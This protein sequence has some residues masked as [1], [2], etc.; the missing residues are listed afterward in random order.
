VRDAASGWPPAR[1][2]TR[3]LPPA[4]AALTVAAFAVF[5]LRPLV[6]KPTGQYYQNSLYWV[7]WYIGL[8]A[9]LLGAFGLAALARRTSR[10]LLTWTDHRAEARTWA[11]PL[12]T[13]LWVIVTVLWRPDINPDQPWAST[14]L[15]PFV[16]PGL[17]LGAVWASAWLGE[18]AGQ[19]GQ[20]RTTSG[21][22]ASCCAASLLIPA[23][24]T[25][26]DLDSHLH[27]RGLAFQRIGAGEPGTVDRLCATIGPDASVVIL[28]APTA[29]Q[30]APV[31]RI[32]CDTPTA[33]IDH[34]TAATVDAVI[35]GIQHAGRRP[36]LLAQ[37]SAELAPY[38]G[39]PRKAVSLATTEEARDLTTP[40]TRTWPVQYT[41]WM[42]NPT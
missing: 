22:V 15:V 21:L 14:R 30:F 8:P 34:P 24:L 41:V 1:Q 38:G 23:A 9:V 26:L 37:D 5:A 36:V 6:Q 42:S 25:N 40:P 2:L 27:A 29:D 10:A 35:S 39:G 4:A 12:L 33:V 13:A 11:L 20:A 16:L 17:I 32:L 18:L 31:S 28:G 7:I 3:W 19:R